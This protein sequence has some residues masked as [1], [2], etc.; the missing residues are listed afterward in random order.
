[1]YVSTFDRVHI[2]IP[3]LNYIYTPFYV[4]VKLYKDTQFFATFTNKIMHS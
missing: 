4:C 2:A 1:M 3:R